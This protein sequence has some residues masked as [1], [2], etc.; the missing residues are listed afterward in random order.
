MPEFI[1]R[2]LTTLAICWRLDRRDG[3]TLGFTAHDRD[4]EIGGVRYRSAPGMV[5]S[6]IGRSDGFDLD[7][8]DVSGALSDAAIA[9][10]DLEA[11]R[12]DGSTL[13]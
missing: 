3:V 9:A 12:W 2:D 6:A 7:T 5:P 13:R 8:M 10:V 4:L 1:E 11:G